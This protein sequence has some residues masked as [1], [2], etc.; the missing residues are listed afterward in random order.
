MSIETATVRPDYAGGSIANLMASLARALGGDTGYQPLRALPGS[1]L[2]QQRHVVLLVIDGLGDLWLDEQDSSLLRANRHARMTSVFPST[3]ATAVT[4]FLTGEPPARHGVTGWFMYA[5]ELGC[6]IVPLLSRARYGGE[7]LAR[8]GVELSGLYHA[9]P[10]PDRITTEAHMVMP[11][12]IAHSEFNTVFAGNTSVHSYRDMQELFSTTAAL[13][14]GPHPRRYVYAYWPRLDALAHRY[15]IGAPETARHFREIDSGIQAMLRQLRGRPV[16]V[17]VTADHGFV[18][19]DPDQAIEIA[20]HDRLRACL[21][22][23]LCGERRAAFCYVRPGA[24]ETFTETLADAAGD[25]IVP[26]SRAELLER[27]YLGPGPRHPE[28]ESRIGDWC[29]VA[30]A[31]GTVL[32]QVPGERPHPMIGVHGGISEREMYVPLIVLEP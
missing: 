21:A 1:S 14:A 24:Q 15:G 26:L 9:R 3:T 19:A 4:T 6:V 17:V 5:R 23:P 25:R 22:A 2:E 18:D 27:E 32:D 8:S 28:L 11:G 7:T 29:L 31:R 10:F 30:R 12:N 20:H 16:T 13:V